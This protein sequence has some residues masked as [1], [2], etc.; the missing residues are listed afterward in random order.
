MYRDLTMCHP[1]YMSHKAHSTMACWHLYSNIFP[2]DFIKETLQTLAL[3]LPEHDPQCR[4]WF[5]LQKSQHNLDSQAIKC[6]HLSTE[7]RQIHKFLF[8]HDRLVILKQRF[9]EEEPS[10]LYQWWYDRRKRVQWYTFWVAALVLGL[11]VLF[12]FIQCVEGGLQVYKAYYPS[13]SPWDDGYGFWGR[14]GA[15]WQDISDFGLGVNFWLKRHWY[16]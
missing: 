2:K 5:K 7:D 16:N 11:T 12:G 13:A 9:D 15:K 10:T 14:C 6:G 4:K 3:I 1:S 8:W